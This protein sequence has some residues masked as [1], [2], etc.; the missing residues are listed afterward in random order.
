MVAGGFDGASSSSPPVRALTAP[1]TRPVLLVHGF[2]GTKSSWSLVAHTLNARGM[3][4][5]AMAA[6][7]PSERR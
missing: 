4:V 3:T 2:A 7:R 6:I 5:E 1:T